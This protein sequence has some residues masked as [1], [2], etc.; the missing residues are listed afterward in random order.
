MLNKGNMTKPDV[1]FVGWFNLLSRLIQKG[2]HQFKAERNM[3][4]TLYKFMTWNVFWNKGIL[5]SEWEE[6]FNVHGLCWERYEWVGRYE[7]WL[8]VRRVYSVWLRRCSDITIYMDWVRT[9]RLR[10]VYHATWTEQT[11]SLSIVLPDE[12]LNT[13]ERQPDG[14]IISKGWPNSPVWRRHHDDNTFVFLCFDGLAGGR[15]TQFNLIEWLSFH[16]TIKHHWLYT[17]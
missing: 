4:C 2:R 5:L 10:P 16:S 1:V 13:G 15:L 11:R 12:R 8:V 6:G 7:L 9:E 14:F 3:S 17:L